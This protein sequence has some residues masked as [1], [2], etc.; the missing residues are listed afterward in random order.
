MSQF[1]QLYQQIKQQAENLRKNIN[2]YPHISQETKTFTDNL[3]GYT[4][5]NASLVTTFTEN[6]PNNTRLPLVNTTDKLV[7]DCK[8]PSITVKKY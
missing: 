3:T 6:I 2:N 4:I 8:E 7:L 5:Y 1:K